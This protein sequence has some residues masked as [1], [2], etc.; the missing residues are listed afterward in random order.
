MKIRGLEGL[1]EIMARIDNLTNSQTNLNE[2]IDIRVGYNGVKYDTAG[3]SVRTQIF[4]LLKAQRSLKDL[5]D[6]NQ[7]VVN[8]RMDSFTNLGEGSTTA[9]AELIDARIDFEGNK[10]KSLGSSIREADKKMFNMI[11]SMIEMLLNNNFSTNLMVDFD[12][13][14]VDEN[15]DNVLAD[16]AYMVKS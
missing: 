15:G 8:E 12:N 3:D 11:Q 1:A 10:K 13:Y 6:S 9:D 2:L 14:V 7:K 4:N 16:W 5:I